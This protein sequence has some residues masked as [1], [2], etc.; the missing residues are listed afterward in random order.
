Y[1]LD[2]RRQQVDPHAH[3][4][5]LDDHGALC[6]LLDQ[7]FILTREPGGAD[8]MD[9]ALARRMLGESDG[10]GGGGE[11]D[12]PVRLGTQRRDG[13]GGR[14][15]RFW[16]GRAGWRASGRIPAEEAASTAPARMAPSVAAMAWMRVRPMRP[17]APAT[18]SRM[19]DMASLRRIL[20][21]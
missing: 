16:P 5:G 15:R 3:V 6:R 11:G 19:S 14:P 18:I 1:L 20:R 9:A 2:Q 21:V 13:R 10:G 17:P 12:E 7:L 4:A 8:D